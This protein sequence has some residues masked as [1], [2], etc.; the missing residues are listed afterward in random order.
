M[1][2]IFRFVGKENKSQVITPFF[3]AILQVLNSVLQDKTM[4]QS[5][6]VLRVAKQTYRDSEVS[7][8]LV[9]LNRPFRKWLHSILHKANG[10]EVRGITVAALIR[11]VCW[12]MSLHFARCSGLETCGLKWLAQN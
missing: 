6:P 2:L 10:K 3:L 1:A 12:L 8:N 4:T 5:T 11:R 7:H 9:P